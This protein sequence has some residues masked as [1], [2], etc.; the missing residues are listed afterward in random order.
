MNGMLTTTEARKILNVCPKTL[1][2]YIHSRQL[3]AVNIS[4]GKKQARWRIKQ[5]DLDS[6]IRER[7]GLGVGEKS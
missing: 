6:F 5:D 2:G 7:E 1:R 4:R 3:K